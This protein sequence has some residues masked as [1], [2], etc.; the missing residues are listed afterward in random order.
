VAW[1]LVS[2]Q[3]N[4]TAAALIA[5]GWT[6]GGYGNGWQGSGGVYMHLYCSPGQTQ[7]QCQQAAIGGGGG[8][9]G[10]PIGPI[11]EPPNPTGPGP[12][13]GGIARRGGC[14]GR[15]AGGGGTIAAPTAPGG[16][17]SAPPVAGAPA[18][19][20]ALERRPIPWW[21]WVLLLLAAAGMIER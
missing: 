10:G 3:D 12:V 15:C 8:G 17:P 1:Q 20:V 7:E 16:P 5:Q 18:T 4:A 13:N 2:T 11:T 14:C 19:A 21:V 9:G 6:W